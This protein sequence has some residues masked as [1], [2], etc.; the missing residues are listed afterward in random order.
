MLDLITVLA[1]GRAAATAHRAAARSYVGEHL[2]NP[3]LGAQKVTTAIGI[4]AWQLSRIFAADATSIPR[5]ILSRR[6]Q[7]AYTLLSVGQATTPT[8]A[9]IAARCGFTSVTYFSHVFR[10]HFGH[11]ATDIRREPASALH[12]G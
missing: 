5:H 11:R 1:G 10:R 4:S 12:G 6:L 2:T 8:V 9:D 3:D 7:L